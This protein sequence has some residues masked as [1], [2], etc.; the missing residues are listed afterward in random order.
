MLINNYMQSGIQLARTICGVYVTSLVASYNLRAIYSSFL[1]KLCFI[2]LVVVAGQ[3]ASAQ[4]RYNAGFMIIEEAGG[5]DES[6]LELGVWYPSFAEEFEQEWGP[7]RP[8]W[9]WEGEPA[10]GQYPIILLSHGVMGRYRNHRGTAAELARAGYVVIAP[11]HSNDQLLKKGRQLFPVI[12]IRIDELSH[13]LEVAESD[14]TI[15]QIMDDDNIGALG[16]SLGGLT[17]LATS[18]ITP[19]MQQFITH[20]SN[21]AAKDP[22][23]S[24]PGPWWKKTLT[25]FK[26][27]IRVTIR[28][29]VKIIGKRTPTNNRKFSPEF[30]PLESPVPFKAIA[31][32]APAA[33]IFTA[34]KIQKSNADIAIYRLGDDNVLKFPFHAEHL[35]KSL[36]T[37]EHIYK[38]Y[39]G[40][41]H[42]AFISP[43][44]EWLLKEID[45]PGSRDPEGFDR[46]EFLLEINKD[47]VDFFDSV[48]VD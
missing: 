9:A 33:V 4:E 47:I 34:E 31:V 21:N 1:I 2:L 23:C 37:R 11:Q 30:E 40:V 24:G 18:G 41:H 26:G 46:R 22:A 29:I 17:V 14:A 38:V 27:I 8:K 10:A 20:C 32:V 6:G 39:E 3:L 43:F 36:G 45:F 12:N 48:F 35:H 25:W 44:P 28:G 13:T 16:Y 7:F 5:L 19:S 15:K 42:Y